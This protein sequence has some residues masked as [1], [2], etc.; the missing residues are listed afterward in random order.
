MA[1]SRSWRQTD[2]ALV[3]TQGKTEIHSEKCDQANQ[4]AS[5]RLGLDRSIAKAKLKPRCHLLRLEVSSPKVGD[6]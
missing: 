3:A 4:A 2:F 1:A 5:S 6:A